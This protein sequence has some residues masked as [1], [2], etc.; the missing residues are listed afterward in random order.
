MSGHDFHNSL[1]HFV[2]WDQQEAKAKFSEVVRRA[3][4]EGPQLVTTR[5]TKPVVVISGEDYQA[6]VE[7]RPI[8]FSDI[9]IPGEDFEPVRANVPTVYKPPIL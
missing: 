8:R 9:L 4:T 2:K 1:D 7:H 5:G 6:L 3:R